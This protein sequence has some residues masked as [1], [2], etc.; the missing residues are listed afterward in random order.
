[1]K[2]ML[3]P[4][5]QLDIKA[6]PFPLLASVKM[7]GVRCLIAKGE[8]LSRSLKHIPNAQL[9][10]LIKEV[11]A[12]TKDNNLILD[13]EWYSHDIPFGDIVGVTQTHNKLIPNSI[14][15]HCF[16]IVKTEDLKKP[17]AQRVN[18]YQTLLL[19]NRFIKVTQT[20]VYSTAHVKDLMDKALLNGYEGL[21]L[22]SPDGYYKTGRC[23][24]NE[25]LMFKMKP[26]ITFD[27]IIIAVEQATI[28]DPKAIKKKNELG[29]SVTSKKKGDRIL[30]EQ[31]SAFT[32]F[33]NGFK[34][35]VSLASTHKMSKEI[36][37]NKDKYIGR[38]IEY[39]G[40]VIGMKDLPRH[41]Q[42]LR[43]RDDKS[44]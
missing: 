41:P 32:V 10:L 31:A 13:G 15:Y 3:A 39:R 38:V 2:P 25:G 22:K 21:I 16:D 44:I 40:M 26:Y 14:N 30:V 27:A 36:W 29:G 24:L 18:D 33:F 4:N 6:L 23:T 28:V 8:L 34:L 35:S 9:K 19:D 7:D 11:C 20:F 43:F 17:F 42:F 5:K 1:M 37:Q 12:Y